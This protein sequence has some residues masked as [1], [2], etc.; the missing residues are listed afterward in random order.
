[1]YALNTVFNKGECMKDIFNE[2]KEKI[3]PHCIHSND[4]NYQDCNIVMQI[5]G[6]ANCINYVCKDYCRKR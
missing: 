1:M 6:Q 3:C 4:E 5:D 2:Y